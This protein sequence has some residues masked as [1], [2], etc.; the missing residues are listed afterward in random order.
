MSENLPAYARFAAAKTEALRV[1]AA[2]SA[3]LPLT[4]NGEVMPIVLDGGFQFHPLPKASGFML[5][6]LLA[7]AGHSCT[8][9]RGVVGAHSPR[10]SVW[11]AV[12]CELQLGELLWW[13]ASQGEALR[14]LQPG[15]VAELAPNEA[16][17]YHVVADCQLYSI[18][19]P[20]LEDA[21]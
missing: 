14:L 12:R 17:S 9:L 13:Q 6:R 10:F 15:D 5:A 8:V 19:T 4:V 11:Q 21:P 16:H 20:S 3:V 18:F 1:A 2:V 7:P